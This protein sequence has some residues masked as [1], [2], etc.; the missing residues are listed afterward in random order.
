MSRP[1]NL[2]SKIFLDGA[3]PIETKQILDLMGFLDGQTTNPTLVAKSPAAQEYINVHG[4]FTKDGV[5]DYYKSVV[6]KIS[7]LIP[8][9]S[10]S[11]EVYADETVSPE[12]MFDQA[13]EMNSWINNAHIKFPIIPAGLAAAE[14]AI[15]NH[16]RVNMTLCFDEVQAAAVYAATE[17]ASRGDVFLSPFV[18]R[19]DDINIYGMSLITNILNSLRRGD[20]HVEVLSASIRSVDH[21]IDALSVGSD[22]ITAPFS[23]LKEWVETGMTVPEIGEKARQN[24]DNL[25]KIVYSE[26]NLDL[27]WRSYNIEHPLTTAGIKKFAEDWNGLIG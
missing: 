9:G 6:E 16:L 23:V 2:K 19:L 25:S 21:L 10:V 17:G 24:T 1:E 14:K 7:S 11:I 27:P 22:I 5:F 4:P 3:D 20:G 8:E 13:L 18:G 26:S 12:T 15:A